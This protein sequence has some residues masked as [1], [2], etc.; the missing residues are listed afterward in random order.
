MHKGGLKPDSF[1]FIYYYYIS[2][3]FLTKRDLL[4][5][6]THWKIIRHVAARHL[7][8]SIFFSRWVK[9][10]QQRLS[11]HGT[12]TQC[13]VIVGPPSTTSAQH[14]LNIGSTS[15]ACR[16]I[17]YLEEDP[18]KTC[19][20]LYQPAVNV[21]VFTL[22]RW[23][24]ADWRWSAVVSGAAFDLTTGISQPIKLTFSSNLDSEWEVRDSD[25]PGLS[26]Y[27]AGKY[28]SLSRPLPHATPGIY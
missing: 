20:A 6:R 4:S 3:V 15:R 25:T 24:A 10:I 17:R 27:P 14:Q 18:S 21:H 28:P 11:K 13:W 16:Q 7:S 2:G 5:H 9:L 19:P 8:K 22:S 26:P 12:L 23:S 1:H